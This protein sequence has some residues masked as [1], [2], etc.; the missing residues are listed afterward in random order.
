MKSGKDPLGVRLATTIFRYL[1]LRMAGRLAVF[2][3]CG[4]FVSDIHAGA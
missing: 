3:D 1:R 4:G 2:D